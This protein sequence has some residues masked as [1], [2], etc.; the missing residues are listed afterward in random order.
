MCNKI[1]RLCRCGCIISPKYLIKHCNT[2]LR[3]GFTC[4]DYDPAKTVS[5]QKTYC[6]SKCCKM[7]TEQAQGRPEDAS[8][9][10]EAAAKEGDPR[11]MKQ[12]VGVMNLANSEF[13]REA[14][15]HERCPVERERDLY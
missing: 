14:T 5:Q 2:G 7:A 12:A 1:N 6:C 8:T 9:R 13:G 10:Y 15:S 11:V 3:L 4:T